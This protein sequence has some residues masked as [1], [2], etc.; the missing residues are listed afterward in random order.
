MHAHAVALEQALRHAAHGDRVV[1]HQRERCGRR[2]L[3]ATASSAGRDAP[4]GAHQRAH[5]EDD[6]DAAVAQDRR[7]GDAA[8]RRRSA[9]RRDLTTISRLP[10]SSSVTSAV[11]CSPARTRIDR[12]RDVV[13]GQRRRPAADERR[14]GAGSDTSVRRTRSSAMFLARG[15][16]VIFRPRQARDA[17]DRRQRQREV[18]SPHAHDQRL[19]DRERERQADRE[20]RAAARLR[21]DEADR[22]RAS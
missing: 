3:V 11:E 4:F 19:R 6:D 2:G 12:H 21:L 22:R 8:D 7:A 14:R 9:G 16:A 17:F 10:T 18:S 1:D 15:A 5:V 13:L 20:A